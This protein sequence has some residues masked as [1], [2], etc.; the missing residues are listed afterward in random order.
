MKNITFYISNIQ[1]ASIVIPLLQAV[2]NAQLITAS[3]RTFN[4]Y[5]TQ[6]P[7]TKVL[8]YRPLFGILSKAYR[9]MQ[10]T[11]V[12]I[13]ELAKQ[14]RIK[15]FKAPKVHIFHG[16]F[17]DLG[18]T[19]AKNLAQFDLVLTNGPRQTQ[20]LSR[21]QEKFPSL[22]IKTIGYI[23][24]DGFIKKTDANVLAIKK[25]LSLDP[26]KKT[27]TY[28]PARR[29]CGSWLTHAIKIAKEVPDAY[30][31]IMRPHPNQLNMSDP[32]ESQI[33]DELKTIFKKLPHHQLDTGEYD[34]NELLC[35]TD[36]LISDATSPTEEVLYYDTPQILTE[37]FSSQEWEEAYRKDNLHEDDIADLVKMFE[38]GPSY[39]KGNYQNWQTCIEDA[40]AT[41]DQ[42]QAARKE[43][44]THAFGEINQSAVVNAVKAIESI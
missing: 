40:F 19:V 42:Y 5:K 24:F 29:S 12:F 20:M 10:K 3:R 22:N 9:A 30:N 32:Q 18:E 38:L 7:K 6:C 15:K 41:S 2:P 4:F 25:K 37:T 1:S 14:K 21:Y 39:A 17:R 43:Y 27:I 36:L 23:P 31:L 13:L 34:Y 8:L 16:T 44:F 33:I 28:L 35:V 26:N 11:D